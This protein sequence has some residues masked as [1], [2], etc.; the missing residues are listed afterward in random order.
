[1]LCLA[2]WGDGPIDRGWD[3][4]R[5]GEGDVLSGIDLCGSYVGTLPQGPNVSLLTLSACTLLTRRSA[6]ASTPGL[7]EAPSALPLGRQMLLPNPLVR[8]RNGLAC[9]ERAA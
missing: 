9:S 1:M 3:G 4:G 7:R 8:S 6:G 5:D 2:G